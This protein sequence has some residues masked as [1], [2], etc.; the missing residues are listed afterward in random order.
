MLTVVSHSGRSISCIVY[1]VSWFLHTEYTNLIYINIITLFFY[2]KNQ[3]FLVM[4][5][6]QQWG[7]R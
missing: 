2:D 5:S 1:R 3:Y 7:G 4:V 6:A